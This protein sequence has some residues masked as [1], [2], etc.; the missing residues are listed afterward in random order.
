M[1]SIGSKIG[2]INHGRPGITKKE[3]KCKPCLT[4]PRIITP[5]KTTIARAN[6]T[7]I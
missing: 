4:K 2:N 1:I 5:I 6:V 7:I 3:K